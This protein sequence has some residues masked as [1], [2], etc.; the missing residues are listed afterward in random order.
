MMGSSF[1]KLPLTLTPSPQAG[2]RD[3]PGGC[4]EKTDGAAAFVLLHGDGGR[5]RGQADERRT[6]LIRNCIG[7]AVHVPYS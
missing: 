3:V 6:P 5:T 1:R 2:R 7:G 4:F